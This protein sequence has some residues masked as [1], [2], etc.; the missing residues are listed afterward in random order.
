MSENE[1]GNRGSKSE[2]T[3]R[4]AANFVKEQRADGSYFGLKPKLRCALTGLERGYQIKNPSK[5]LAKN[6]T[7]LVA[8]PK[9]NPWFVTGFTDAEGT[10]TVVIVKDSKRK[11][12]WRVLPKYQ[13]CLHVRDFA[14]LLQI[15]Q[16]FGGIGSV[17]RPKSGESTNLAYYTVSNAK[18]LTNVII[19][20]FLVYKLLT[21]KAEDFRLFKTIVE[22]TNKK[23]HT[24]IEGLQQIINIKASLNNRLSDVVQAEFKNTTPAFRG[25]VNPENI[26][27]PN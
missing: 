20:H 7:T 19:P 2:F 6:F 8:E 26:Q 14:L 10:F 1:M 16:F 22:H 5:Q 18:D 23:E 11:V 25:T 13:I 27:D 3:L 4:R 9:L 15:Q 12:G 17:H 21:Q 24:T